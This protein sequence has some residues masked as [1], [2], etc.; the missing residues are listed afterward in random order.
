MAVK[1]IAAAKISDMVLNRE[2]GIQNHSL[3]KLLSLKKKLPG[4][5]G[6]IS[7]VLKKIY[8]NHGI[9]IANEEIFLIDDDEENIDAAMKNNHIAYCFKE[10]TTVKSFNE[11]LASLGASSN[12]S[13]V[14]N[15]SSELN[16]DQ[17]TNNKWNPFKPSLNAVKFQDSN[18]N[19]NSNVYIK[20]PFLYLPVNP[21]TDRRSSNYA[22]FLNVDTAFKGATPFLSHRNADKM[23][24]KDKFI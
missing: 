18:T 16:S 3:Q 7:L 22:N 20:V 9:K 11:Y 13:L 17:N 15:H 1:S 4:K 24:V 2:Y 21:R 6:H 14:V 19:N 12:L 5:E 23:N 8:I 10:E